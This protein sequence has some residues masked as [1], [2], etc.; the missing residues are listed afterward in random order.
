MSDKAFRKIMNGA[1]EALAYAK[2]DTKTY[3]CNCIGPQNGQPVCPCAMR[4]V[5]IEDGRYVQ[6]NDLGPAP[7]K[8]KSGANAAT[9]NPA[10]ESAATT[11]TATTEIEND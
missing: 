10:P 7:G 9:N 8:I 3:A 6:R 4:G 5:T 2:G 11:R 1:L